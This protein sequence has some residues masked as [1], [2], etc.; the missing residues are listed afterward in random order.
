MMT[1]ATTT[2]ANNKISLSSTF[3]FFT[4]SISNYFDAKLPSCHK[5]LFRNSLE[6]T[7]LNSA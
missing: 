7:L 3:F 4:G 1:I 6:F 2:E 5:P